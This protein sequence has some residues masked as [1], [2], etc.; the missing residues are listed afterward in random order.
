MKNNVESLRARPTQDAQLQLA[1]TTPDPYAKRTDAQ[2]E[3]QVWFVPG[4][5]SPVKVERAFKVLVDDK[6]LKFIYIC[7]YIFTSYCF[8]LR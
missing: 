6:L 4:Y 8:L 2:S 3:G 7:A 1:R 5:S